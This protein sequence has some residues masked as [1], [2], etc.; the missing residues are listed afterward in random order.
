[1]KV[2]QPYGRAARAVDIAR[3][4]SRSEHAESLPDREAFL[5]GA[6]V[7]LLLFGGS[8]GLGRGPHVQSTISMLPTTEWPL[9]EQS[10]VAVPVTPPWPSGA[11]SDVA[12]EAG[13]E[14]VVPSANTRKALVRLSTPTL[15]LR[16]LE[17]ASVTST[18]KKASGEPARHTINDAGAPSMDSPLVFAE[19]EQPFA[20]A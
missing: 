2:G 10:T 3:A 5:P 20:H 9:A 1:M 6:L 13:M 14:I 12:H 17:V 16:V 8:P 15:S 18:P 4:P 7:A 19:S 11:S